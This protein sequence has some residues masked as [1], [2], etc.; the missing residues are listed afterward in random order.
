MIFKKKPLVF[1]YGLTGAVLGACLIYLDEFWQLILDNVGISVAFFGIIG[2]VEMSFKI[3]GNLLAYRLKEK[4]SYK[5]I[6]IGILIFNVT[7]YKAIYY[8][9]N[10]FCLIPMIAISLVA[11]IVEPLITGY[12]HHNTESHIRATVESFSSLGLRLISILIGLIFGYISTSFSLFAAFAY[13]GVICLLYLLFFL[14][15]E[16]RQEA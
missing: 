16:K 8:T 4:L 15:A 13:L 5:I 11:G 10:V 3:P 9:R 12:L 2:A 1:I 14:L 7:G 6:L